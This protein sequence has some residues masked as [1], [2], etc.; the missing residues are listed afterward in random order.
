MSR[1]PAADGGPP[2]RLV[3]EEDADNIG[4]PEMASVLDSVVAVVSGVDPS[5][6]TTREDVIRLLQIGNHRGGPDVPFWCVF[7]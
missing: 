3:A 5:T 7:V 2:F 1:E 6:P 4:R